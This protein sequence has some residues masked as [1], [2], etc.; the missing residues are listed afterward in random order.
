[1]TYLIES[2]NG[3]KILTRKGLVRKGEPAARFPFV[4]TCEASARQAINR[5]SI[6]ELG[7]DMPVIVEAPDF[8][9]HMQRYETIFNNY[10]SN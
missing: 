7:N 5:M 8:V 6:D 1:M 4:Y 10:F 2:A 3:A 9:L